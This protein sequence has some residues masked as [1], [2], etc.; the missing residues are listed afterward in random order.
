MSGQ[1]CDAN[2]VSETKQAYESSTI[3]AKTNSNDFGRFLE[4]ISGFEFYFFESSITH[5][6]AVHVPVLWLVCAH[7]S[8]TNVVV[9]VTIR[10]GLAPAVAV[11]PVPATH[12]KVH[13]MVCKCVVDPMFVCCRP[14]QCPTW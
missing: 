3:R 9:F 6:V 10:E 12:E 1:V 14:S 13:Y 11:I 7:N 5:N 8:I 4:L 2:L